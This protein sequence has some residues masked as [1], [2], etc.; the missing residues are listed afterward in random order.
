MELNSMLFTTWIA[1]LLK[2]LASNPLEKGLSTIFV[3][4]D[5]GVYQLVQSAFT[6]FMIMSQ[7]NLN[8]IYTIASGIV[9]RL[10]VLIIVFIIFRVG[11]ALIQYMLDP[12]KAAKGSKK[13]LLNIL[14]CAA[15]LV[16]YNFVFKVA[17]DISMMI[18][19]K[20]EGVK[21]SVLGKLPGVKTG[22]DEGALMRLFFATQGESKKKADPVNADTI[23]NSIAFRSLCALFPDI[24]NGSSD[25][26][27]CREL[28]A[29]IGDGTSVSNYNLKKLSNINSK[30]DK[31]VDGHPGVALILG[32]YIIYS[33]IKAAIEIGVRMFKLMLLQIIAPI[34]IISVAS[35]DGTKAKPFSQYIKMYISVYISAFTRISAIL[36]V[37]AFVTKVFTK[38]NEITAGLSVKGYSTWILV[39]CMVAGYRF[40]GEMPKMLDKIFETH[41]GESPD[42]GFGKFLTTLAAAPVLGTA[43]AVGGVIGAQNGFSGAYGLF[44][45]GLGGLAAAFKGNSIADKIKAFQGSQKGINDVQAGMNAADTLGG[46]LQGRLEGKS[47]QDRHVR[48]LDNEIADYTDIEKLIDDYGKGRADKIKN[49]KVTADD[50]KGAKLHYRDTVTSEKFGNDKNDFIARART[51][52]V[53]YADAVAPYEVAKANGGDVATAEYNMI[54]A[55]NAADDELSKIW[56]AKRNNS[57]EDDDLRSMRMQIESQSARLGKDR[58][59]TIDEHDVKG[60]SDTAKSTLEARVAELRASRRDYTS[61]DAYR[62][63]HPRSGG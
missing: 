20:P 22:Y 51:S 29:T 50:F 36:L 60:S 23:G 13:L 56:E 48:R 1:F 10:K 3:A 47:G 57:K 43:G 53:E 55:R 61:R 19:G 25:T 4:L 12:E 39:I 45:G 7:L 28:T 32:L 8:I 54:K 59:V 17:N 35:D 30:L 9:V 42:K 44:A 46:Y 41:F 27:E 38:L 33:V 18:I 63:N 6:I 16:S 14:I 52:N 21:Y 34:A 40:A 58:K 2:L 24:N 26:Q 31:T 62:S 49:E 15:L 37:T 5:R 11:I